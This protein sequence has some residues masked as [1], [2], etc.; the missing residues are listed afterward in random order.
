D[1]RKRFRGESS[2]YTW[3][4]AILLNKFRRW[5]RQKDSAFLSLSRLVDE[6]SR[7]S[8]ADRLEAQTVE[9]IENVLQQEAAA[10]VREAVDQLSADHR[11]VVNLRYVEDMSYQEIADAVDCPLGTVKSRIHYALQQIGQYLEETE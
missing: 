10:R 4:Y 2:Y 7:R 8:V 9:P 6:E 11:A 3:L 1:A 5:L